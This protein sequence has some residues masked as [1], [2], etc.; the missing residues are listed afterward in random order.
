V[1]CVVLRVLHEFIFCP[2][3]LAFDSSFLDHFD[4]FLLC[5]FDLWCELNLSTEGNQLIPHEIVDRG[6]LRSWRIFWR[7]SLSFWFPIDLPQIG[8]WPLRGS[9][10]T[11]LWSSIP[12]LVAVGFDLSEI[13]SILW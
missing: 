6:K 3:V 12:S 2:L 1:I 8:W 9:F 10:P 7:F 11:A 4:S 13:G 5:W